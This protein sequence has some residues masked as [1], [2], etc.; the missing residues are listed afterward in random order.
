MSK[1]RPAPKTTPPPSAPQKAAETVSP[2]AALSAAIATPDAPVWEE[3]QA[4]PIF[5]TLFW[6]GIAILAVAMPV[7]SFSYGVSGDENVHRL[8]GEKA[9]DFFKTFGADEEALTWRNLY[10]YGVSFDLLVALINKT[11]GIEAVYHTRHFVN[12][13][14]GV[15]LFL[16]V[17]KL[18]KE[19]S[20]WRGAFF[21][22]VFIVLSP[23]IFGHSMNN[24]KDLP[25]AAGYAWTLLYIIRLI[26]EMPNVTRRTLVLTALAMGLTLSIRVGGLL[27]FPYLFLFLGVA[28]LW[29]PHTRAQ[30]FGAGMWSF[31]SK[32]SLVAIGAYFVGIITW[33]YALKA[34]LSNPV[35]ALGEMEKFS[36]SIRILFE[37]KLIWSDAVPWYY[38]PKWFMITSP[39]FV[40]VG[41]ILAIIMFVLANK[42]TYIR[43]FLSI[44]SFAVLFPVVY[45]IYKHSP[46]YDGMRHF[47]FVACG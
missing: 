35:K 27:V 26:K 24:L 5:K 20:G 32:I 43:L 47:L 25:F 6:V 44:L 42:N 29:L 9:L 34:P 45:A 16:G 15:F 38:I 4:A 18:T 23:A 17:G 41:I 12:A 22:L 46:L 21:S 2:L 7:L 28:W 13:L 8:Y 37:G 30:V 31:A 10:F 1:N 36:T 19:L 11:F 3:M 33:P 40:F 39:L 14:C